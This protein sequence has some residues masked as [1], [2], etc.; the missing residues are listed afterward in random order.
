MVTALLARPQLLGALMRRNWGTPGLLA[1]RTPPTG[2]TRPTAHRPGGAWRWRR[3]S[4]WRRSASMASNSTTP[5][6][7]GNQRWPISSHA[8]ADDSSM[9]ERIGGTNS[10]VADWYGVNIVSRRPRDSCAGVYGRPW[11][12][13]VRSKRAHRPRRLGATTISRPP[14]ASTRQ[15]SR[16]IGRVCSA[17]SSACT[18][19]TRSIDAVGEAAASSR[20]RAGEVGRV[21]RPVQHALRRRHQ[22]D[23]ALRLGAEDA[24]KGRGVAEAENVR[25]AHVGPQQPDPPADHP[26]GDPPQAGRVKVA[27]INGIRPHGRPI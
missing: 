14:S 24:E 7:Q 3:R 19:R 11:P 10:A 21:G 16:I 8:P 12:N 13:G 22:R 18:S 25:A 17:H 6:N 15:I 26:A 5:A 20:R 2:R 27:Q 9:R 1:A 23:D 4:G